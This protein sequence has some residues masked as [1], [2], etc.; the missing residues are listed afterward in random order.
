MVVVGVVVVGA[1]VDAELGEGLDVGGTELDTAGSTEVPQAVAA[2]AR[3]AAA[4][5]AH[6]GRT[7]SNIAFLVCPTATGIAL[8]PAHRRGPRVD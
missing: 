6:R 1:V 8:R 3:E 7:V 4:H 5:S 2:N